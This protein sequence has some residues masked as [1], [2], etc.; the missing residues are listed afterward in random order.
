MEKQ[1]YGCTLMCYMLIV[2][3]KQQFL[4]G[5]GGHFPRLSSIILMATDK[6]NNLSV[7]YIVM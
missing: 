5:G 7:F 6:Y 2:R 1:H 4:N 3:L